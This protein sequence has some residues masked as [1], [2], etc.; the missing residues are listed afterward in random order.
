MGGSRQAGP[1]GRVL[2]RQSCNAV[3]CSMARTQAPELARIR[4][5]SS[6]IGDAVS[7]TGNIPSGVRSSKAMTLS[8]SSSAA[9]TRQRSQQDRLHARDG[10]Q[11][12]PTMLRV[13]HENVSSPPLP[14]LACPCF[15][16]GPWPPG[17]HRLRG[18]GGDE[19]SVDLTIGAACRF[20]ANR[21]GCGPPPAGEDVWSP[22]DETPHPVPLL[23]A[24]PPFF[25]KTG[26]ILV[27]FP[28]TPIS[29]RCW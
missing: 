19:V 5:S 18:T 8:T 20:L 26:G 13:R 3:T 4:S 29:R 9:R 16:S 23:S 2:Q 10:R 12:I 28:S 24:R 27:D 6:A 11:L 21:V 1:E 14:P 17:Q 7:S 15:R 25:L 22:M